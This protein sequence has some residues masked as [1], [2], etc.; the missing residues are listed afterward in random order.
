MGIS[1]SNEG[2]DSPVG[3]DDAS[4]EAAF[5]LFAAEIERLI[6]QQIP[7]HLTT[8]IS[9]ADIVQDAFADAIRHSCRFR[10]ISARA[11]RQWL[12]N[13][14]RYKLA[15]AIKSKSCQRRSR[16]L[17]VDYGQDSNGSMVPN[18]NLAVAPGPGPSRI[19]VLDE[20]GV[21]AREAIS[22][23]PQQYRIA[24]TMRYIEERSIDEIVK[25]LDLTSVPAARILIANGLRR[26]RAKMGR[27]GKYLSDT[28]DLPKQ[29]G[30]MTSP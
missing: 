30:R 13:R 26:L 6:D 27:P 7:R 10:P 2:H 4:F 1:V 12:I 8:T 5:R 28:F 22:Q 15:D 21:A 29:E 20:A 18:I 25:E 17:R 23:L 11:T 3:A 24:I 9:A 19:A 14:A 16:D